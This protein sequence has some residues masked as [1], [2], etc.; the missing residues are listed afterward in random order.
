MPKI[1]AGLGVSGADVPGASVGV[2]LPAVLL[3]VTVPS[4]GWVCC[5]ADTPKQTGFEV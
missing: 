3:L 1:V 2:V 4:L 5:K